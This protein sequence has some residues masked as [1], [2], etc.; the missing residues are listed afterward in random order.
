ML[1]YVIVNT[2]IFGIVGAI[3]GKSIVEIH[4][5]KKRIDSDYEA[6]RKFF[7][8]MGGSATHIKLEDLDEDEVPEDIRK[9][10]EEAEL[11]E[12]LGNALVN[13][14][15]TCGNSMSLEDFLKR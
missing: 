13:L 15:E 7:K 10:S 3:A 12:E 8:D 2:I 9:A 4:N 1:P 11:K 6:L 5:A 14:S